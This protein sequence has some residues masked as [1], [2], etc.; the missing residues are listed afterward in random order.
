MAHLL[1]N[2]NM[3]KSMVMDSS[4]HSLCMT[5]ERL[6]FCSLTTDKRFIWSCS[7][8]QEERF[9]DMADQQGIKNKK[10]NLNSA[11]PENKPELV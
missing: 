5:C 3:I 11:N 7:E 2:A 10:K 8:Y 6:S 1:P 9:D 4:T